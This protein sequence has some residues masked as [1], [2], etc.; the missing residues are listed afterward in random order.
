MSQGH[1]ATRLDGYLS[2]DAHAL[3]GG[4]RV[5][6][7]KADIRFSRLG[8]EHLDGKDIVLTPFFGDVD[9]ELAERSKHVVLVGYLP[10]V[11][12]HI[13]TI[14]DAVEGENDM[15]SLLAFRKTK[16]GAI[17]PTRLELLSIDALVVGCREGFRLLTIGSQHSHQGGRNRR[18]KPSIN[19]S[20][21][22]GQN[23][24]C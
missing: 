1:T 22:C 13:G 15:F 14:A 10:A 8:T 21:W 18:R 23:I 9:A 7:D 16:R 6:I 20:G 5:P 24:S 3:I 2:E 19:L 12:P 11:E 4:T 17:P